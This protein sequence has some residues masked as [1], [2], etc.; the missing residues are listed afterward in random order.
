MGVY[1][2]NTYEVKGMSCVICKNTVETGI[3][4]LNGV[5][6]CK[7]NL[8]ENEATIT[9]DESKINIETIRKAVADLGYELI[10]NSKNEINYT[11]IKMIASPFI[12]TLQTAIQCFRGLKEKDLP[13]QLILIQERFSLRRIIQYLARWQW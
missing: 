12:R 8:L 10:I 11:K 5:K 7:V 13:I 9:F 2:E 1:M 4:R 3:K 6:D